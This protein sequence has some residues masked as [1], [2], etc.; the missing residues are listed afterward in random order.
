MLYSGGVSALTLIVAAF[1]KQGNL[2]I[3]DKGVN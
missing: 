1:A 3:V 2:L